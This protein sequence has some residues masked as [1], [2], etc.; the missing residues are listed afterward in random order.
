MAV[1]KARFLL[2]AAFTLIELIIVVG[3]ISL[4]V[5]M[6]LG[7]YNPFT[8]RKK[9]EEGQKRLLD[10]LELAKKKAVSGDMAGQS[11]S[12]SFTGYQVV[13]DAASYTLYFCCDTS[14]VL[15]LCVS[16]VT[17]YNYPSHVTATA[18][19]ALPQNI[20]F[21]P[22]FGDTTLSGTVVIKLTNSTLPL[23]DCR[24]ISITPLGSIQPSDVCP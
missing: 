3:I 12:K 8:E 13:V 20:I 22:V 21:K 4:I 24:Q 18:V 10:T 14:G 17:T 9:I 5:T 11:C 15:P 19:P 1:N 23:A 7:Y 2:S 6:S 16:P